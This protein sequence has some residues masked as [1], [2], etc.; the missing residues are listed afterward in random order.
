MIL[1]PQTAVLIVRKPKPEMCNDFQVASAM[2]C[3]QNFSDET[4]QTLLNE[5]G[6][7]DEMKLWFCLSIKGGDHK[8]KNELYQSYTGQDNRS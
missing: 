7:V 4:L 2:R 8:E 3:Q 1:P 5:R 6:G